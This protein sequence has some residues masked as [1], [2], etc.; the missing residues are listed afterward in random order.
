VAVIGILIAALFVAGPGPLREMEQIGT[1]VISPLEFGVSR[2]L[3]GVGQFFE[4]VQHAGD[5]AAQNR[6]Y[7]EEIDRLQ[8]ITVQYR[9]L[10]QENRDLR[11]LLGLRDLAP[12]GSLLPANVI[13][14]DPL[15]VV[16]SVTIDRGTDDGVAVNHPVITW[17]GLVGRVV[18]VHP[19]SAK[20]LLVT[21]VNSAVSARVQDPGSRATGVVRGTGDGR[22]ILQYVPRSD[23]LRTDGLLITSGIGGTFPSGIM[24][25]RILQI[26]QKDVEVFQEALIE[27][28]AD[29][30]NLERIYVLLRSADS[31]SI[32]PEQPTQ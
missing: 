29:L 4:T 8:S 2:G 17:R 14:R 24:L 32:G 11:Q 13:A 9:E 25:G 31:G 21:D 1:R 15:A 16:Q 23:T 3:S 10:E 18:E 26:R 6:Q 12:P 20:V 7:R 30:R 19:K 5:L 27:P 28:S 22:L